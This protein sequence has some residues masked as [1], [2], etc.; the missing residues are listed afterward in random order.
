VGGQKVYPAEVESVLGEIDNIDSASVY[1]VPNPLLGY[2]VGAKVSLSKPEDLKDL[3]KKI[4][5]YCKVKMESFKVPV[6]IEIIDSAMV[7]SRFKKIR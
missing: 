7:S 6:H 1:G 3:K 5:I 2:V 4:R